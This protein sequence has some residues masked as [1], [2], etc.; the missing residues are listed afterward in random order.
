VPFPVWSFVSDCF[1]Q[2]PNWPPNFNNYAIKPLIWP[3]QL[4]KI[5]IRPQNFNFFQ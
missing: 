4:F 3:H 2:V 5:I 1:N